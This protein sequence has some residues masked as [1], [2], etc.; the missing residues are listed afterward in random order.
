[1]RTQVFS[2]RYANYRKSINVVWKIDKG[3]GT[4]ETNF[5]DMASKGVKH[6]SSLFK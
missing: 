3:D 4:W 2:H 5:K 6:L 1:M